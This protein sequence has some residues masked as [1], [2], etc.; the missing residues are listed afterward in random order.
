MCYNVNGKK[1]ASNIQKFANMVKEN[2]DMDDWRSYNKELVYDKLVD[3]C[4]E[5]G[6][7]F[8][9]TEDGSDNE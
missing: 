3:F 4:G 7:T 5:K 8:D 6:I 1:Y 2:G 9:R